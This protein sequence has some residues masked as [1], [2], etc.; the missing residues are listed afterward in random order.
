L[1]E[2]LPGQ[3]FANFRYVYTEVTG[4][5]LISNLG[6]SLQ[7]KLNVQAGNIYIIYAEITGGPHSQKWRP[8]IVNI[9]DYN[10]K[11]CAKYNRHH[12]C[13]DKAEI[14]K[15]SMKYLQGE[16]PVLPE[17]STRPPVASNTHATKDTIHQRESVVGEKSAE[18]KF[19]DCP[20][21]PEMVVIP[22][23]GTIGQSFAIGMTEVTQRQWKAIMGTNPSRFTLCGD[24]CPV[25]RVSW[26]DA[27]EFIQKLNAKTGK[28]YRLPSAAEW[29]YACRA[30]SR[31]EYC[32]GDNVN[33]VAWHAGNSDDTTHPV[34]LKKPNG[35]GLYDM[36][37]NV[38]EWVEDCYYD[39]CS[40]R[41]VRGGSWNAK[42]WDARAADRNRAKPENRSS[43]L[44]FRL[45][46]TPP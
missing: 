1:Y 30:G 4:S 20:D 27:K 32:G 5:L 45:A 24:A 46:R 16:R 17:L 39:D 22:A 34:A 26:D 12:D 8:I 33:D 40:M 41:V 7:R 25:E 42:P 44:G 3:Y 28:Q 37:G 19:R 21:C 9:N 10:K 11:E 13:P 31:Q 14:Q 18:F 38:L 35:Y 15:M 36:S 6:G 2:L 29:E 23:G 43:V